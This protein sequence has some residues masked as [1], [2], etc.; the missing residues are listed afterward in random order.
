LP[1]IVGLAVEF[2]GRARVVSVDL[3]REGV[4]QEAFSVD[5]I[6]AYVVFRDGV[7]VDRLTPNIVGWFL[8]ARLRRMVERALEGYESS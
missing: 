2:E 8:E 3:D 5:G 6:P 4:V 1:V 7:E